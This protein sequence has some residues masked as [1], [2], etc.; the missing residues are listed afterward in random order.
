M[1]VLDFKSLCAAVTISSIQSP[2]T[3]PHTHTHTHR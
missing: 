2:D 3:H 1:S